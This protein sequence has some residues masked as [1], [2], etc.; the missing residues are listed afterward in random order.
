MRGGLPASLLDGHR[1]H[2]VMRLKAQNLRSGVPK[3]AEP[4][5]G[6]RR[7]PRRCVNFEFSCHSDEQS[8]QHRG[9][10]LRPV[11]VVGKDRARPDVIVPSSTDEDTR[12]LRALRAPWWFARSAARTGSFL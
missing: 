12:T 9:R 7:G 8:G 4:E 6:T 5:R 2:E 3:F 11:G 1:A 10:D